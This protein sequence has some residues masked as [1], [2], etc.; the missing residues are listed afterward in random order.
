MR[1]ASL[2]RRCETTLWRIVSRRALRR[3]LEPPPGD[4]E[5]AEREA[6]KETGGQGRKLCM[7]SYMRSMAGFTIPEPM[8]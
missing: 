7:R 4:K 8:T 1:A 3:S 6:A 5:L 2:A